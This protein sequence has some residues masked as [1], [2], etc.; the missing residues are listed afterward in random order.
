MSELVERMRRTMK[1]NDDVRDAI[2]STPFDVER[3]DDIVYA[4]DDRR[5]RCWMSIARC[6]RRMRT[7]R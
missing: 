1:E 3:R 2:M 4:H 7:C 6:R 5:C